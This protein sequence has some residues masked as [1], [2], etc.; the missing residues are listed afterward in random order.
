MRRTQLILGTLA[1]LS[2][3]LGVATPAARAQ[4]TTQSAEVFSFETA[5]DSGDAWLLRTGHGVTARARV[6]GL[7]PGV[8][9][10][11]WVVWNNPKACGDDGCT[12]ADFGTPGL[13]VDIG[14]ATGHVV[15]GD[16][17]EVFH[18]HLDEGESLDGFPTEFGFT[19]G[20]GLRDAHRAEIHLVIRSHGEAIPG[21]V[22]EMSRT[23]NAGCRYDVFPVQVAP[24]Y[25]TPGPHVCEDQY[26]A[27]LPPRVP[28]REPRSGDS[29]AFRQE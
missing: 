9:T 1:V 24:V 19:S 10:V 7:E 3:A 20:S 29:S 2:M 18:T 16:G 28:P 11:W 4:T 26:F 25:G 17:E 21:L 13:D 27:V 22:R 8:Y 6:D 15:S 14:Y 5:A 23:F 12:D